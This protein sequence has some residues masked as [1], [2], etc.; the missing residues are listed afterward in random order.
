MALKETAAAESL[1]SEVSNEKK[2]SND[3]NPPPKTIHPDIDHDKYPHGLRLIILAGASIVAVFL[4][5]LDQVSAI[6][7]EVP[8]LLRS[9]T[10]LD[11]CRHGDPQDH[12]RVSQPRRCLLVCCGVFHDLWSDPDL[13][14]KNLQVQQSQV[15]LCSLYVDLR[16]RQSDLWSCADFERV[17]Y[18]TRYR[19]SR[20]SRIIGW[21]HEYRF[22]CGPSSA[23]TNDDGYHWYDLCHCSR[24]GAIGTYVYE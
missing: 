7:L 9:L 14:G 3:G 20:W 15:E 10:S 22:I 23:T 8:M 5:A 12:R 17:D 21:W 13:C 4:I 11:H 19:R 24:S 2:P 1:S 16:G 6:S 18:R